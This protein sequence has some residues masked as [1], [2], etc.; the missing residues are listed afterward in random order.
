LP[1]TAGIYGSF[2]ATVGLVRVIGWATGWVSDDVYLLNQGV[3]RERCG[4]VIWGGHV[5]AFV[6]ARV[7]LVGDAV[8]VVARDVVG[9]VVVVSFGDAV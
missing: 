3:W 6:G 8:G 7:V 4:T 1:V 5:G 2:W 9:D